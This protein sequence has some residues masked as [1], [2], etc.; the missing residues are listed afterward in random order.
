MKENTPFIRQITHIKQTYIQY[1]VRQYI[2]FCLISHF[3]LYYWF[4][5][6]T[7]FIS[8]YSVIHTACA[9]T[10]WHEKIEYIYKF[11]LPQKQK[12]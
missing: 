8:L 5:S 12:N 4:P 1:V 6:N 7:I 9:T 3:S 10:F 11:Q 2:F